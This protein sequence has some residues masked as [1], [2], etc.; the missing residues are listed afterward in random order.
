MQRLRRQ[1]LFLLVSTTLAGCAS[2]VPAPEPAPVPAPTP[3]APRFAGDTE[4]AALLLLFADRRMFD[5]E[6]LGLML[7]RSAP[8][9]EALAVT[10]GRIGDPRGRSLLQGLLVDGEPEVRRA[11][12]FGLGE[13]GAPEAK[14]ALLRGAIDDD[15]E[16]GAL[17]VE[18]LGKLGA[19][20]AEVR[21]VLL[22]LE[23]PGGERRLAPALFRFKEEGA[24]AVAGELLRSADP[25]V[26]SGAAYALGREPRPEGRPLLLG[27]LGD[28]SP[29]L[30]A[31]AARGL[32]EAG[33]VED[34]AALLPLAGEPEA[35]P[36]IQALRAGSRILQRVEALPPTAWTA[37][38]LAASDAGASGVRAAAL[39]AAG[40]FLPNAELEARLVERFERGEPRERELALGA[41][42]EGRADGVAD[43]VLAASGSGARTL[44]AQAATAAGRL[45]DRALLA[46]LAA[47]PEPAVRAAAVEALG[48]LA[49]E[50]GGAELLPWLADPDPTVRAAAFDRLSASPVVPL[51]PILAALAASGRDR[52]NDARLA[53]VRA[54]AAR[55]TAEPRERAAAVEALDRLAVDADYLVRREAGSALAG[56][57]APRPAAGAI[58]TGHGLEWYREVVAQTR[59]R[60]VV[61]LETERG[62]LDL[63]LECPEAPLTCMSFYKLALQGYFDGTVFHRVVPDFVVQ[64]GDP[65]GDGWG[66]P[67]YVL[68]D[69][70]NRLRY[71]RGAVGMAL[72]GPDTGGSQFFIALSPQPH[73]DGGYTV[74]GTL[75]AGDEVLDE[76]RQGD[77]IL[78]ARQ[79]E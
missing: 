22:A 15:A 60:P 47:D 23:P 73:L 36:R 72:S 54:L 12:A 52:M 7:G 2:T 40:A 16:T 30:R 21:R 32:G 55:A 62:A 58:D 76:I 68:R 14:A 9:R 46:A 51:D 61:R 25:A 43:L 71:R 69:E 24:V 56:L 66:G 13:L 59:R 48:T 27:L 26:R 19:P 4:T 75:V 38:L 6:G 70:I 37:A 3:E 20:L 1:V 8:E 33:T 50:T 74:F 77:R 10:L 78:R 79:V 49:G 42:A 5:A 39:E 41:L 34:L 17:A 29:Q 31:W 64:G 53:G 35:S 11:A 28:P 63:R 67:G 65:R 45:G 57:G 44:R 18:A